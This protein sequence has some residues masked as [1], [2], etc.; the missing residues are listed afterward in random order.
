MLVSEK[1]TQ[2]DSDSREYIEVFEFDT[3]LDQKDLI[4]YFN[5][6]MIGIT[7]YDADSLF[8]Y[9]YVKVPLRVLLC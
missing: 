9:G 6:K 2:G 3:S 8:I 7:M 5:E 4:D 1:S